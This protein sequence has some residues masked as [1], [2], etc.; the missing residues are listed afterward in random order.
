MARYPSRPHITEAVSS[1]PN[2]KPAG[3]N[4]LT[5]RPAFSE[6]SETDIPVIPAAISTEILPSLTSFERIS[7]L[8]FLLLS[9]SPS[10]YPSANP[11]GGKAGILGNSIAEMKAP[12][13][14]C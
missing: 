9:V 4:H 10:A 5:S 3:E 14:N 6:N 13:I 7:N 12:Q 2:V 1:K 8:P 11:L